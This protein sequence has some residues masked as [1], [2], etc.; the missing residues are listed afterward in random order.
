M[1]FDLLAMEVLF[2]VVC[3]PPQAKEVLQPFPHPEV[4]LQVVSVQQLPLPALV[5]LTE[6]HAFPNQYLLHQTAD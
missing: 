4:V 1:V 3:I 6:L 5:E 2:K